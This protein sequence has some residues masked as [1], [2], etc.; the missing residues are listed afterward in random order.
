VTHTLAGDQKPQKLQDGHKRQPQKR[1][2][3]ESAGMHTYLSE[4]S[5]LPGRVQSFSL[6]GDHDAY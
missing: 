3:T 5:D 6:W 2:R 1:Q 4:V